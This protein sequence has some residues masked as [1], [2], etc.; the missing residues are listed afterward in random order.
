MVIVV[1]PVLS[2]L[3]LYTVTH[4]VDCVHQCF[5]LDSQTADMSYL[6]VLS[7]DITVNALTKG[8][9]KHVITCWERDLA[10][11]FHE[12]LRRRSLCC[13]STPHDHDSSV[14]ALPIRGLPWV[15]CLVTVVYLPGISWRN[16]DSRESSD[17]N[18]E[19]LRNGKLVRA[20][21]NVSSQQIFIIADQIL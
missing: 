17:N 11:K 18:D 1:L 16:P 3:A 12:Q 4:S 19:D 15:I 8:S 2:A 13:W 5:G 14:L 10:R 6:Y 21:N 20:A 7:C 9:R